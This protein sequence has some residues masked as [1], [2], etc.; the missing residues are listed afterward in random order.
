MAKLQPKYVFTE[1]DYLLKYGYEN[2][3]TVYHEVKYFQN[4][5][6]R[7]TRICPWTKERVY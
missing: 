7:N 3:R 6:V 5:W 4:V 2:L 1:S